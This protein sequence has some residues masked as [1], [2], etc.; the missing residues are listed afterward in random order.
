MALNCVAIDDEPFALDLMQTYIGKCADLNLLRAFEDAVSGAEFLRNNN[1]DVLFADIQMPD[2]TG[3]DLVRSLDPKPL[4]IFTTAHRKFAYEGYEL[5]AIDYLLKP[6]AFERFQKAVGKAVEF[7]H[8]LHTAKQ[9]HDNALFVY[10]EYRMVKIPLNEIDYIESLEDYIKIT[11]QNKSAVMTLMTLKSV[12][13]KL[14]AAQFSRIHRSY[15]VAHRAVKSILKK[16]VLLS[17]GKE[18]PI[19]DSHLDFVDRWMKS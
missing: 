12:L 13:E 19:S 8:Y 6:I 2:I 10:A 7:H 15:I 5:D 14:P 3:L 18:L 4:L 1:V 11:L 16:R 9:P 17:S